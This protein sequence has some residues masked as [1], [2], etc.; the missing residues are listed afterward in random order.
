[1]KSLILTWLILTS[2]LSLAQ[3]SAESDTSIQLFQRI[4]AQDTI[5]LE[6][7]AD[8]LLT[9][10]RLDICALLV[11]ARVLTR[12]GR[13]A[14]ALR[15]S[16]LAVDSARA[17]PRPN[18]ES[19]PRWET[20]SL[21]ELSESLRL[22]DKTEE[23]LLVL[24]DYLAKGGTDDEK[25]NKIA[26]TGG[27]RQAEALI[28]LGRFTESSS[29]I[30]TALASTNLSPSARMGWLYT[31]A[32]LVSFET[33]KSREA[34]DLLNQLVSASRKRDQGLLYMRGQ[35]HQGRK[36]VALARADHLASF[37]AE[38]NAS[39]AAFPARQLALLDLHAGSWRE[40]VEWTGRAWDSLR[41]KSPVLRQ[42]LEKD[43]RC[44]AAQTSVLL[45]YP[46][47]ALQIL[48][49]H[50]NEPPRFGG[51]LQNKSQWECWAGVSRWLTLCAAADFNSKP[52]LNGVT[53]IW[54]SASTQLSA[55][56][57]CLRI[58]EDV[59]HH[60]SAIGDAPL[61]PVDALSCTADDPLLYLTLVRMLGPSV[62]RA[63]LSQWPLHDCP[64]GLH[65]LIDAE[66]AW[67]SG[68]Q[69]DAKGLALKALDEIGPQEHVLR[70]RAMIILGMT[71]RSQDWIA[72]AWVIHPA[73]LLMAGERIPVKPTFSEVIAKQLSG[74]LIMDQN[75]PITLTID[76]ESSSP[77]AELFVFQEPGKRIT[78]DPKD[79]ALAMKRLLLCPLQEGLSHASIASLSGQSR[80]KSK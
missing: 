17:K 51:S 21:Y 28:K 38:S 19:E 14:E 34:V 58:A 5:K 76:L 24:S 25:R 31:K 79:P 57:T 74:I 70:A 32:I 3:T 12:R 40:S 61:Q 36:D 52:V 26:Y 44:T 49:N 16:R 68:N 75:S 56:A 22:V 71:S 64:V 33:T 18:K 63:M 9:E 1:M 47:L 80:T 2:S 53:P 42:D 60:L 67:R 8:A 43:M 11:K 30:E 6:R 41:G 65:A 39:S 66:I 45:G 73:G 7:D 72:K 10:N 46:D 4:E 15:Q 23:Q 59:R 77:S 69:D 27:R 55:A 37:N 35:L 29:V 48:G 54:Q 20:L 13:L 62:A 50:S 78:L